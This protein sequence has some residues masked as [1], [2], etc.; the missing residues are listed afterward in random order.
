MAKKK[1]KSGTREWA[2]TTKN[3][4]TGCENNCGYCYAK[5]MAIRFKRATKESWKIPVL[6]E[7]AMQEIP[8][9][10]KGRIMFPSTHD[11]TEDNMTVCADYLECWLKQ[12]NEFLIVSKP[13]SKAIKYLCKRLEKFKEQIT[14]RFTIGSMNQAVLDFWEHDA[15]TF[16]NRLS[17]LIYAHHF[18][19]KTSVSCE[20]YLDESIVALVKKLEP[21]VTDSIWIGKMNQVKKRVN[22]KA[23]GKMDMH[24]LD[25]VLDI[26][27]DD[28]VKGMYLM[29]K[30]NPK[31]K[32]KESV[33]KVMGLAEEEGVA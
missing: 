10:A 17:A 21:Y 32:W 22:V 4:Q 27:R 11:I 31:V 12:G 7:K 29:F 5:D 23:I 25:T 24:F 8:Y 33:K 18:G 6:N 15:P 14:F 19:W 30:D 26:S 3:L 28:W 1:E 2:E 16:K 13:D 9:K 20:P